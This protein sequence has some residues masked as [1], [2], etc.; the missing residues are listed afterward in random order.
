MGEPR[1]A[2]STPM[3]RRLRLLGYI[4]GLAV[5]F[6]A[7]GVVATQF[8]STPEQR[9]A[10]AEAPPASTLT[11]TVTSREIANTVVT[12]GDVTASE[13]VDILA[14]RTYPSATA[15][16]TAVRAKVGESA[17]AGT[18]VAEVNGR[19]ILALPGELPAYEDLATGSTGPLVTQLQAALRAAGATIDDPEG[20]YGRSTA[21]AV[22]ELYTRAG[23]A[24]QDSLPASE[25]AFVP[26]L[27]ARVISSTARR[28]GPAAE[29]SL[30]LAAGE[31]V[32]T[33]TN[34]DRDLAALARQD[35]PVRLANELTGEAADATIQPV[36]TQTEG[37]EA[38]T[39]QT[40]GGQDSA[41]PDGQAGGRGT[42]LTIVPKEPLPLTWL[43]SSV[44]VTVTAAASEGSVLA[45]PQAAVHTDSRGRTVVTVVK[46]TR[47]R[48]VEVV[49]GA[50]GEG[51]VQITGEINEGDEVVIGVST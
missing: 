43:D 36:T 51:Y 46:D 12:R 32:V 44:R 10:N 15:I 19:P 31:L 34:P 11:A 23:Y 7:G 26:S 14:G 13:A 18:A 37:G 50:T 38:G 1:H 22:A 28:G 4:V 17:A 9:A 35:V 6:A 41:Q 29:A 21:A 48:D 27:P 8:M 47:R 20:L 24:A 30:K 39:D 5:A 3:Q 42:V 33:I 25:V 40:A 2:S 49:V 45:V 16:F